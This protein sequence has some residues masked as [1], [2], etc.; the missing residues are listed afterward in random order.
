MKELENQN[1]EV[2]KTPL[3]DQSLHPADRSNMPESQI[4]VFRSNREAELGQMKTKAGH[5]GTEVGEGD[6]GS[7]EARADADKGNKGS[8]G[9]MPYSISKKKYNSKERFP[10]TLMQNY[11]EI[12]DYNWKTSETLEIILKSGNS[13][14]GFANALKD[15]LLLE[16]SFAEHLYMMLKENG[17]A[18]FKIIELNKNSSEKS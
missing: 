10:E 4:P 3:D 1:P 14:E 13:T 17:H 2:S 5:L 18:Y 16:I 6:F 9:N 12:I 11:P 15:S 8:G 7:E